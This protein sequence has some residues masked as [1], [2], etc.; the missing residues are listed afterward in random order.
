KQIRTPTYQM[1]MKQIEEMQQKYFEKGRKAAMDLAVA[2]PMM[3]L[4][5]HYNF[6]RKRLEDFGEL[7]SNMFDSVTKGY[8]NVPDM[9][10]TLRE[11]TGIEII[12]KE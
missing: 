11:E 6:G 2:V 4:R 9:I 7:Y 3:V 12:V 8:L 10:R 5:D 1:T